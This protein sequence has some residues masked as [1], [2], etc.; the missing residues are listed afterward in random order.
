MK[1]VLAIFLVLALVAGFVFA[2]DS[3][4]HKIKIKSDVTSIIPVFGLRYGTDATKIT[5]ST[6][7][8]YTAAQIAEENS[9]LN[10]DDLHQ[11]SN[12]FGE[13]AS[14]S[15]DNAID[16]NFNLDEGGS[17]TIYAVL[18][19]P[20]K[21]IETYNLTFGGGVF[22]AKYHGDDHPVAPESIVTAPLA[23]TNGVV[24]SEGDDAESGETGNKVIGL[25]FNGYPVEDN[26]PLALA[27]AVYTYKADN[28]VDLLPED[29]YYYADVTLLISAT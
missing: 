22:A 15:I 13:N 6:T 19:N 25:T 9:G 2:A 16:V 14:Y 29:E 18:L 21:Q 20:A 11:Y 1:K 7:G 24:A 4:T 28:K 17:V 5:N 3:E 10:D 8:P 26:L 12:R 23:S 27:S